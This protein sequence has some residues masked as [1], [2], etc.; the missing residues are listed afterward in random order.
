MFIF[1]TQVSEFFKKFY[2]MEKSQQ[3][4]YSYNV[5]TYDLEKIN[6]LCLGHHLVR[7]LDSIQVGLTKILNN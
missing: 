7:L 5:F 1:F 2:C 3:S 6:C 4:C